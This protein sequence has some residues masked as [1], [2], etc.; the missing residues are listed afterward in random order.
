M[1]LEEY[2]RR[3]G[4]Q[5]DAAPGWDAIDTRLREVYG[6]QEPKHWGSVPKFMI[7]GKDPIDG[8]SVY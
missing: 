5:E 8:I 1:D 7:G 2:R 3:F 4:G 6:D